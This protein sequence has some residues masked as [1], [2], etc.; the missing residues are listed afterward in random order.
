MRLNASLWKTEFEGLQLQT[1]RRDGSFQVI[2]VAGATSQG[3][4]ADVNLAA[5]DYLD[6]F[7]AVQFLDADFADEVPGLT[8]GLPALGGQDIPFAS[9]ITG[10]LALISACQSVIVAGTFSLT[11]TC[12]SGPSIFPLRNRTLRAPRNRMNY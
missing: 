7:F 12:F 1:L 6:V 3:I 11:A 4:E 8:P 10:I 2:N 5:T 9:D